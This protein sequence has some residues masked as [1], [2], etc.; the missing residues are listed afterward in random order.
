MARAL[1]KKLTGGEILRKTWR[2]ISM[3]M[4]V[5]M[6]LIFIM[7]FASVL[8]AFV[9]EGIDGGNIAVIPIEGLISTTDAALT[10]TV[11]SSTILFQLI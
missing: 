2:I 3:G 8:G 7:I 10:T 5:L 11:K 1:K 9:P 6:F 4:S